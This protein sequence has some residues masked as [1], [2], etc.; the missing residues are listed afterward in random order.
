MS[1][2]YRHPGIAGRFSF[3]LEVIGDRM[4]CSKRWE[5]ETE[6]EGDG[7]RETSPTRISALGRMPQLP[8]R[9]AAAITQEI[10]EGRL[11]QGDRLAAEQ[12]LAER[13]EVSRNVVREAIARL[14]SD[15]VLQSRQGVGA[16]VVASEAIAMLR[17]DVELMN[18]R[19]VF[20]NVFELRAIIEIR[21]AGLA[22]LRADDQGLAA[23]SGALERMRTSK[24]WN[25]DGVAAD[26]EFHRV[27]AQATGNPYISMIV[28]GLSGQ[29]HQSIMFIRHNQND[30]DQTEAAMNISEHVAIYEAISSR[31]P[32]AAREAMRRHIT[33]AAR[34]LGYDLADDALESDDATL[35]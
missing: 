14:R 20:R 4:E 17:I 15:G 13:F 32:K 26:L 1:D 19:I 33:N 5:Y 11:K 10:V 2:S 9:V 18:D 12:A 28:S 34:R 25:D 6:I 22:A 24:S 31:S 21:A 29:M 30:I 3:T 16:F 23:I 27:I 7:M 8:A 35:L